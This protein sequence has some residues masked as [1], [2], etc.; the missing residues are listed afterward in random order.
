[1]NTLIY[2]STSRQIILFFLCLLAALLPG[3]TSQAS[4]H[5]MMAISFGDGRVALFWP[6]AA[7]MYTG[8]GWQL[9]DTHTGKIVARWHTA[10]LEQNLKTLPPGQQHKLRPFFAG[11]K[12]TNSRKERSSMTSWLLMGGMTDFNAA[13]KLGMATVLKDVPPGRRTYHLSLTNSHGKR[14]GK[15]LTSIVVDSG[16][17]T[18]LPAG[19]THLRG[20]SDDA[21]MEL[22]WDRIEKKQSMVPAPLVVVTRT[23]ADN[24]PVNLTPAPVWISPD[25]DTK[26]PAYIDTLAPLEARLTYSIRRMDI[27]G[28]LSEP[29]EITVVNKDVAALYPPEKITAEAGENEVN[30]HWQVN[31]NPYTSGYVIERSRRAHGIYEVLTTKGLDRDTDSYTDASVKGGFVY[32]YRV[33][34]MGL[35]GDVGPAPDPVSV[36]VKTDGAPD[37]PEGLSARVEPT[38]VLLSWTAM[39]L[40]VAG[41]I[42]EKKKKG[43]DTWVRINSRLATRPA[44]EDPINLGDY[45]TRQYRVT[46]VA[47]GNATSDPGDAITVTLPGHPLLPPPTLTDISTKN[48]QVRLRFQAGKPGQRTKKMLLVR[49]NDIRDLGLVIQDNIDGD[50]T[51]YTDTMVKPG[52]DYWYGLIALDEEGRRSKMSN[53][54]FI[55]VGSPKIPRPDQPDAELSAKPFRRV[56]ITFAKPDGFLRASVMR[57]TGNGPWTTISRD[58]TGTGTAVDADPPLSGTVSYRVAYLDE[59][60]TWGEPSEPVT[61]RLQE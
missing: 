11:L 48:G 16:K 39:P 37:S 25:R 3:H 57:K 33:R 24:K 45:G 34:A 44:M 28:R 61:I 27:F 20:R 50:D 43:D 59:G 53:K 5:K 49:G 17:A 15:S 30:L 46:A 38:R 60:N 22:Y 4:N 1:M 56:T 35:R 6:P 23:G 19:V 58:I 2:R 40:P 42:V 13:C 32:Y 7:S 21:G 51:D 41:Y 55:I 18:P 47:F 9:Q 29:A 36:M 14:T 26:N 52:E 10:M 54:L 31:D 12:K 8:G